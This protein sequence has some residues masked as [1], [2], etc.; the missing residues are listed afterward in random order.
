MFSGAL[1]RLGKHCAGFGAGTAEAQQ[2][3]GAELGGTEQRNP[4]QLD[5]ARGDAGACTR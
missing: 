5:V 1:L 3:A 2:G 4:R